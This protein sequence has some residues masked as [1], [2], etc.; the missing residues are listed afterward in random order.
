LER[1]SWTDDGKIRYEYKRPAPNGKREMICEPTEFLAKLAALIPPPRKHLTR[2]HGIFA[3]NH[4]WRSR[5]VP[6]A[7][8]VAA[9]APSEETT[10][11][12]EAEKRVP[13]SELARRLDWATRLMRVFAIDILECPKCQGRMRVLAFITEPETV[14]RILSH[15]HLPTT[16]P[17]ASRGPLPAWRVAGWGNLPTCQLALT[18][19]WSVCGP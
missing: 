14:E 1:L 3:P 19:D 7:P 16:P 10:A 5:I 18:R 6:A 11:V 2:Y 12:V 13:A 8:K 9:T 4:A 15:L 17:S